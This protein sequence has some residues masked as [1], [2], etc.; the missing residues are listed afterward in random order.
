MDWKGEE[1]VHKIIWKAGFWFV[2]FACLQTGIAFASHY[3]DEIEAALSEEAGNQ[4]ESHLTENLSEE[5]Q[6]YAYF[7]LAVYKH[8]SAARKKAEA[9]YEHLNTPGSEA[10]LGTLE[11]LEARDLEGGF[12]QKLFKRKRLVQEG[13][14]KIDHAARVHPD[15]PQVCIVRAIAYLRVPSLFGKFEEGLAD[16]EKVIHWMEEGKMKVPEEEPFFRDRASLY[17]YAGQ[18]YLKAGERK[19]AKEMFSKASA[20]TFH[21]PFAVASRKRIAALS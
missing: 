1:L 20:A 2:L 13:I 21:S 16:M 19:K 8:D 6:A 3:V 11:M 4:V 9:I 12:F 14:E 10:F 5:D 17:Y 15:D 7:L 18:Y